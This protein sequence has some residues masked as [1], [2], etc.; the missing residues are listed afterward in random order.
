M[1]EMSLLMSNDFFGAACI[2]LCF[3]LRKNLDNFIPLSTVEYLF[4]Q[5][6]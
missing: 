5:E 4:M 3:T 1:N 6:F 2:T